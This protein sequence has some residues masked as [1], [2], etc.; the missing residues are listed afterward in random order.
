M[1]SGMKV[2]QTASVTVTV[3][4]DMFAQFDGEVVHP[5]YSTVSM[6]YHMEWASRKIILPF[7]EE[8]EE[9]MGGAVSMKHIAPSSEGTTVTITATLTELQS[10]IVITKAE[11]RNEN[12]LIGIGEVKQVILPKERIRMMGK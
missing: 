2:G 9:G 7:L 4:P 3:T 10:N 12:G 1:K 6:V 8:N 11:A 5:V